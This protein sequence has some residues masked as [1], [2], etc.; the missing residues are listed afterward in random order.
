MLDHLIT[1]VL[2]DPCADDAVALDGVFHA[3]RIIDELRIG[4]HVFSSNRLGQAHPDI[5][6]ARRQCQIFSIFRSEHGARR[7]VRNPVPCAHMNRLHLI[8]LDRIEIQETE[9]RFEEPEIDH[10]SFAA[11][12]IAVIERHHDRQ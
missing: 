8:V 12:Q 4:D 9:H 2:L 3:R 10:L 5:L 11:A 6:R 7:H 1:R